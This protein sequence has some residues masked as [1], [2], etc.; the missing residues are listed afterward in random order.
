MPDSR[1]VVSHVLFG[2]SRAILS[3]TCSV[4]EHVL[5]RQSRAL[6]S[7]TAL[8][9]VTCSVTSHVLMPCKCFVVA[10]SQHDMLYQVMFDS[11]T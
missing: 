9:S 5:F 1:F 7:I 10:P 8:L 4:V 6:S 3:V 2:L 11:Q